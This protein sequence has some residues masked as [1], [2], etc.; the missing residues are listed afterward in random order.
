MER[1]S[2]DLTDNP[3]SSEPIPETKP[4]RKYN[5]EEKRLMGQVERWLKKQE[6][7]WYLKQGARIPNQFSHQKVGVPDLCVI[8]RNRTV[9]VELKKP[10]SYLRP[11]QKE[12]IA[13]MQAAGAEVHVVRTIEE[14]K[15]VFEVGVA[16]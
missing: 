11:K 2:E 13:K 9:W 12:E 5:L 6:G 4:K 14:F 1:T 8:L 15:K 10:G 7:C 3:Q 16:A